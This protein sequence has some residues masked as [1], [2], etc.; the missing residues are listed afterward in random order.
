MPRACESPEELPVVNDTLRIALIAVV[1]VAVWR[2]VVP[3]I[4]GVPPMLAGAV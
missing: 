1:A 4:P 2:M 3:K